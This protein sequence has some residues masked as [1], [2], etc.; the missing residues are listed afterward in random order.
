MHRLAAVLGLAVLAGACT[1]ATRDL[2]G[3]VEPL[4][5]FKLG[6]A[7][8]VAPKLEKLLI[9]RDATQEEWIAAVDEAVETRFRRFEGDRFYHLGISVEAYSLPPPIVP[10]RS[11]MAMRVTV[12]DDAQQQKL[13][14][15]TEVISIVKVFESRLA[16][17]REDQIRMLAEDAARQTEQWLRTQMSAEGWFATMPDDAPDAAPETA[18]GG[19]EDMAAQPAAETG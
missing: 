10:G 8:V 13:N 16:L 18:A 19:A 2:A 4:G 17:S 3:P 1:D 9:S 14:P 5:D 15:E 7:E 6:H 11:A 12:W